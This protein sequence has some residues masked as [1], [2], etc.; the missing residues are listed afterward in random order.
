MAESD[1][2][3][4]S[5][6]KIAPIMLRN[7]MVDIVRNWHELL[8]HWNEAKTCKQMQALLLEGF[9]VPLGHRAYSEPDYDQNDRHEFYFGIADG[10]TD[11]S[12]LFDALA[13]DNGWRCT[14]NGVE[15][16]QREIRQMVAETAFKQLCQ[17]F[18]KKWAEAPMRDDRH[19]L[20]PEWTNV[21]ASEQLLPVIMNFFRPETELFFQSGRQVVIVNLNRHNDRR[22]PLEKHARDFLLRLKQFLWEWEEEEIESWTKAPDATRQKNTTMRARIDAA[23]VWMVEVLVGLDK[24][25]RLWEVCGPRRNDFIELDTACLAKLEEIAFRASLR[26][27]EHPVRKERQVTTL[28]EAYLTGSTAA[29][30]LVEYALKKREWE[31]VDAIRQ[32]E[33]AQEDA[34]WK[35]QERLEAIRK[36]ESARIEAERTL[37]ELNAS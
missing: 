12:L 4:D 2:N 30:F 28:E 26:E 20:K 1:G 37:Q 15:R 22:H 32:A 9:D 19:R 27:F 16:T 31:R 8:K 13:A 11:C 33:L 36:A 14:I 34:E 3:S 35:E 21:V 25:D 10:W 24:L 6:I 5:K 29:R 18:F 23:K 7:R 17:N